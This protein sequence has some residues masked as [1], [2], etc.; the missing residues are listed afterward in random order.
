MQDA[1]DTF[2]VNGGGTMGA[3]LGRASSPLPTSTRESVGESRR[4]V[5]VGSTLWRRELKAIAITLVSRSSQTVGHFA[6]LVRPLVGLR[7]EVARSHERGLDVTG[8]SGRGTLQLM[9]ASGGRF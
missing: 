4:L 3:F 6:Y 9:R 2:G 5:G 8:S 7:P 1:L